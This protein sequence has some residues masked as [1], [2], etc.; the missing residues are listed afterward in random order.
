MSELQ[1]SVIAGGNFATVL[2]EY[3]FPPLCDTGYQS[4]KELE[5]E[6][7]KKLLAL[8]YER[9]ENPTKEVL[10]DNVRKCLER[11]NRKALGER[12]FSDKEWKQ[13]FGEVIA[14]ARDG[15]KEKAKA[16]QEVNVYTIKRDSGE[17]CNVVLMDKKDVFNNICQ[18]FNQYSEDSTRYKGIY[19]V[20]IL[21]NGLPMVHCELKRRGVALKEAFG[22]IVR[23]SR[24]NFWG[25]CGLFDWVQIFV[26]SNG[27]HTKYYSNTTRLQASK[28]NAGGVGTQKRK[29]SH[30]FEFTSFWADGKNRNIVDLVHFA[31]TF[32]AKGTLLNILT[33]YCVLTVDGL[34]LAMRP[35]QIVA[36]ES[37]LNKINYANNQK[38][39]GTMDA[40]GYVWHTTGSGK[41]LTSFKTA[42]L[43]T[44][45]DFVDKVVFVVDRKDLDYQTIKEFEKFGGVESVSGN[46][47][48][49][50]LK[51][52]LENENNKILVTTIQK[53]NHFVAKNARHSVLNKNCVLIFDECHRSQFG[54]MHKA[55]TKAFRNYW[56]FGFTGTPI[57][58]EN[59][60]PG[61]HLMNI[62][63][64]VVSCKTTQD[65]FGKRLH[66]YTIVDA[67]RDKNVLPFRVDL[68]DTIKFRDG[69][70]D[71]KV[72]AVDS[73]SALKHPQRIKIISEYILDY[74]DV[75]TY[76]NTGGLYE[77]T[78]LANTVALAKSKNN[79]QK[80]NKQKRT[81]Q[82]FNSIFAVDS[83]ASAKLYYT[84][85][86][87]QI[88]ERG[89]NLKV[90]TIFC[91]NPNENADFLEEEFETERLD[92]SS[93]DFL[94]SVIAD[95]NQEFATSWSVDSES[96]GGWYKDVSMRVKNKEIDMLIV[97]NMFLT[98]F[99]ATTL[100]TLWV[101]KNLRYHGLI[102]AF[103]RTNRILNSQKRYGNIVSF[104]KMEKQINEACRLF[105]NTNAKNVVVVRPFADYY[106][107]YED[108]TGYKEIVET[109]QRDFPLSIEIV[110][111]SK[112][113][114]FI[115]LFG[116]FLRV[117]N[118]LLPFDEFLDKRI[119]TAREKQ[120]YQSI[121][122]SLKEKYRPG[123]AVSIADDLV[124]EIELIKQLTVDIDYILL[125]IEK[126]KKAKNE[127]E[128][129]V[130]LVEITST[131]ES[132]PELRS[133]KEL[134]LG[135]IGRVNSKTDIVAE[136][137]KYISIET[138]KHLQQII[139]QE[140]LNEAE[141][142][143]LVKYC[144][145]EGELKES[146]TEVDG[147]LPPMSM[148][149][150]PQ[151]R[152][153]KKAR[154]ADRLR[155]FLDKFFM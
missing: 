150:D 29:T 49:S 8:G 113:R 119:L 94:A 64:E 142:K 114:E 141:T 74:F 21:V 11:V 87:K 61:N 5:N 2:A 78:V 111:E 10:V 52:N 62:K 76:R 125:M 101:D 135:F 60:K 85:I 47:S 103:S 1:K 92:V 132:R 95:Y 16:L 66:D 110:G 80:E 36:C 133:K 18:V 88:A 20:T 81:V 9:I 43:A 51:A 91:Y 33:R 6:F 106:E 100:N 44:G 26:I 124:F 63:Q 39:I 83:I 102:Q 140:N 65:I 151:M 116:A 77:H 13:F 105:G 96:F 137:Q 58:V 138:E 14:N 4:E 82:G 122:L 143:K 15:V 23:Y 139:A 89:S 84:E 99:D 126:Y 55:I 17:D 154:V 155:L 75:K 127:Q 152:A 70:K 19:D 115:Q 30:S 130:A 145:Q 134:I 147:V 50:V 73:D 131:I 32:F 108:K 136:W 59:S 42:Q 120:D 123:D 128:R 104:R 117:E 37:I 48:T 153:N 98:G 35:Y 38:K 148:F 118:I 112:E 109:L 28:E 56:L 146:G 41:T 31:D 68:V 69:V 121:Y 90:S 93:R 79:D 71:V 97:V 24:D 107:G 45:L 72:H 149:E 86:K 46:V 53:L 3:G 54:D 25:S 144:L 129:Q 22:Q 27:T 57:F 40:G 67:I 34:L 7:L 12:G